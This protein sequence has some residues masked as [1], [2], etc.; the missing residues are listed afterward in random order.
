MIRVRHAIVGTGFGASVH[1]PA[2]AAEPGVE[3]V[4]IADGGSGS[5]SRL[6]L[7]GV[8]T[9]FDWRRL[10]D[11]VKPDSL[12]VAVPP[13]VQMHVVAG[14]LERGVHVLCE[15]PLGSDVEQA[16]TIA[17][18]AAAADV[19]SA[20][21][22][23]YR[24]EAGMADMKR[25]FAAG[26]IGRLRRVDVSW[27]TA[28]RS[29]PGRAWGWQH[30]AES[31][32]GVLN[33]FVAH[34]ADLLTWLTGKSLLSVAA[35]TSV[36]V[37]VRPDVNGE[38]R[39]VTAE[40]QM[41][42]LVE[43]DGEAVATIRVSNC[44]PGGDGLTILLSGEAGAL[45][46]SHRPPFESLPSIT[47]RGR[48]AVEMSMDAKLVSDGGGDTRIA[49]FRQLAALFVAAVRGEKPADLPIFEDGVRVQRFLAALRKSV[50]DGRFAAVQQA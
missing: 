18:Q 33:G 16:Y 15:K 2:F 44:Q 29:D 5:A 49:P 40:D 10:L 30:N 14:A 38:L 41:D 3:V 47:Y 7:S 43:L 35:R 8:S 4:G 42:A 19:V 26:R 6:T 34:V 28:G 46:F 32:G 22:F 50:E 39:G 21:C 45:Q 20:V 17:A 48:D 12:S 36:L 9:Y 37:P 27:M 1:L 25:E 31:G 24:F 23:Q 11:E 13:A